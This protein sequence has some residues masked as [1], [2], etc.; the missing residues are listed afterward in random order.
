M[1]SRVFFII[2]CYES[3]IR[4][5]RENIN[6]LAHDCF[7]GVVVDNSGDAKTGE[8]EET[9]RTA[10]ENFHLINNEDNRGIAVAI[11][12]GI[13]KALVSEAEYLLIMDDDST[14]ADDALA[15]M[16][17]VCSDLQS[18]GERMA[19]VGPCFEDKVTGRSGV[20]PVFRGVRTERHRCS[21]NK[22]DRFR[23]EYLMSSGLLIPRIAIET[24]GLMREELFID[25]V[26]TEWCLR[27]RSLDWYCYVVCDAKMNHRFGSRC[28]PLVNVPYRP[29]VRHYYIFRN[30]IHVLGLPYIPLAWKLLQVTYLIRLFVLLLV[31]PAD[32]FNQIRFLLKGTLDGFLGKL[33]PIEGS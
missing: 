10:G 17:Q 16:I 27:A 15:R 20:F 13:E 6:R 29:P 2:V 1:N 5:V 32:R 22:S 33:G 14:L 4:V 30:S 26:D 31:L 12:K 8:L 21:G 28:L 18:S 25:L 19:A 7:G 24:V 3:D 11:N 9:V 23:C